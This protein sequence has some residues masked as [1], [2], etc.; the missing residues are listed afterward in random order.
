MILTGGRWLAVIKQYYTTKHQVL[1]FRLKTI[2][3]LRVIVRTKVA[4]LSWCIISI[5][6]VTIHVLEE[7]AI[8]GF[9]LKHT[10]G[11]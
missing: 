9:P 10:T 7:I 6:V 2:L 5:T 11:S 4:N 1:Y 8:S 3:D